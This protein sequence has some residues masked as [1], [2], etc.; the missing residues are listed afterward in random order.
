M[1]L[2]LQAL[3]AVLLV[4]S[5]VEGEVRRKRWGGCNQCESVGGGGG[6]GGRKICGTGQGACCAG[7]N[8]GCPAEAPVCSEWGYCQCSTYRRGG[9]AC[10]PGFGDPWTNNNGGG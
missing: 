5:L 3:V 9:P 8:A 2:K 7:S 6:G 10:G 1:M 4:L